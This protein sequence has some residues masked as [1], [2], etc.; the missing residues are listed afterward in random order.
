MK[1]K[2]EQRT[3]I[4]TYNKPVDRNLKNQKRNEKLQLKHTIN[5]SIEI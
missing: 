2:I 5:K 3:T 1:I 4:E